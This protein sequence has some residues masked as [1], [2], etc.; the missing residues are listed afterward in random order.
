MRQKLALFDHLV[1]NRQQSRW[2]RKPERLCGFQVDDKLEFSWLQYWQ[3]RRLGAFKNFADEYTHL[4]ILLAHIDAVLISP[5][6]TAI[7]ECRKP[8]E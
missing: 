6:D 2:H 3:I 8:L 5:L 1:G 7:L 4:T